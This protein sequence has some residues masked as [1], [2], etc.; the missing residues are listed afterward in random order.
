LLLEL[1][2]ITEFFRSIDCC[3]WQRSLLPQ[4]CVLE[5]L[6]QA[7]PRRTLPSVPLVMIADAAPTSLSAPLLADASPP[8]QCRRGTT[9]KGA[10]APTATAPSAAGEVPPEEAGRPRSRCRQAPGPTVRVAALSG[11]ES[12]SPSLTASSS[13]LASE[14]GCFGACRFQG[15]G[16][17]PPGQCPSESTLGWVLVSVPALPDPAWPVYWAADMPFCRGAAAGLPESLAPGSPFSMA[18]SGAAAHGRRGVPAREASHHCDPDPS[19]PGPWSSSSSSSLAAAAAAAAAGQGQAGPWACCSA[20]SAEV[21]SPT[22]DSAPKFQPA[23]RPSLEV[24]SHGPPGRSESTGRRRCRQGP[25][26][27]TA[28]D[29]DADPS[30]GPSLPAMRGYPCARYDGPV[31]PSAT[32]PYESPA[33]AAVAGF[34]MAWPAADAVAAAAALEDFPAWGVAGDPAEVERIM[35]GCSCCGCGWE[36][37]GRGGEGGGEIVGVWGH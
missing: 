34:Q 32:S 31:S 22:P 25:G 33:A 28:K 18:F 30:R 27:A 12:S 24:K 4:R 9:V 29:S 5:H 8:P 15:P 11:S 6:G 14:A 16:S 37:C 1:L 23:L 17:T 2:V 36:G 3:R 7:S 19:E 26:V 21:P 13:E 20:A 35:G 10:G